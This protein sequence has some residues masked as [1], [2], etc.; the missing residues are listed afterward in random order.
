M[1]TLTITITVP[2]DFDFEPI[3]ANVTE[4][5]EHIINCIDSDETLHCPTLEYTY[6]QS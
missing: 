1:K 6:Q 5:L 2:N 3:I 4:D